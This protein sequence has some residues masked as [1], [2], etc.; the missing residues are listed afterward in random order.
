VGDKR[1]VR[2]RPRHRM[3]VG[4]LGHRTTGV[5]DRPPIW[6][7]NRVVVRARAGICAMASVNEDFWQ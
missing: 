1:P 2:G 6:V 7:R 4:D 5:A 3:G